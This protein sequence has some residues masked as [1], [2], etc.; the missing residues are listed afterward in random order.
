MNCNTLQEIRQHLYGCCERSR[1]AMFELVDALS[2]ESGARSLPELSLSPFFRRKWASVYEALEDGQVDEQRWTNVWSKAL[3]DQQEG[4]I[5][6][7]VD[8][9]SIPRPEAERSADR[10]M[11]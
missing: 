7:S 8:S 1:D 11:I 4:P 5:W 10:G 9:T 6:V 3:L 2:S